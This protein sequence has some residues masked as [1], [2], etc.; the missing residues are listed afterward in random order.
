MVVPTT[1]EQARAKLARPRPSGVMKA[2]SYDSRW[3][4]VRLASTAIL[5]RQGTRRIGGEMARGALAAID[6]PE[7][8]SLR[9]PLAILI[10]VL[11][12]G[13]IVSA[14][15][16]AA[17]SQS[18]PV[19][20]VAEATASGAYQP[21]VPARVLDTRNGT[22][23]PKAPV[24]ANGTVA[25]QVTGQGGVPNSGVGAVVLNVTLTQPTAGGYI[26]VYPAGQSRPT[27]SNLN[28]QAG[29]TIPNLVVATV[30]TGGSVNLYNG[31]GGTVHLIAD[32]AGY[33]LSG[34]PVEAGAY[35]PLVPAR[36]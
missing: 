12:V 13:S 24:A 4:R 11:L 8:K 6:N 16:P 3:A 22:G 27:A 1:G 5:E 19:P 34:T 30:G 17:L 21:L 35:Q 15:A 33:F 31:S 10:A 36:V 20:S 29:Q 32:V 2:D 9:R 26:T 23:A 28:F 14:A 25:L 18:A 7:W